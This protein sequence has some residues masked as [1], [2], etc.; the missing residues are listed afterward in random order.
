[1]SSHRLPKSDLQVEITLRSGGLEIRAKG[2][3]TEL[4][5]E[6]SS[7]SSLASLASSKLLE[8]GLSKASTEQQ[9]EEPS[10]VEAPIIKVSKSTRD[11]IRSLFQT[12]W[13]KTPKSSDQVA[14][15]LETNAVPDSLSNIGV[16]L[17]RLVKGGELRRIKKDG[18]WTYFRITT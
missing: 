2:S 8:V 5:K 9:F 4:S 7:I 18:K 3:I 15:A 1:L 17:I 13:G 14:K 11:N 6:I 16:A 10:L 12:P